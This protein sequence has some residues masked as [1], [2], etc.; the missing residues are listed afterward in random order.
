MLHEIKQPVRILH[1]VSVMNPGGIETLLIN[2]HRKI[3]RSKIQFDFLVQREQ[4]GLYEPEI[5][6]LGGRIYR[7]S[8]LTKVGPWKYMRLLEMFFK[9]HP[10]YQIV[11]SHMNTVSGLIL[12]AAEKAGVPVRIA[13]SHTVNPQSGLAETLF[14]NYYCRPKI[15][16]FATHFFACSQDAGR[17]LFGE[18]LAATRL[19]IVRNGIDTDRFGYNEQ[20]RLEMRKQLGL[21]NDAFVVGHVGRFHPVKNHAFLLDIFFELHKQKPEATLLLVGDGETKPE[22]ERNVQKMELTGA[23][24][25]LGIR[26]DVDKL[27]QA[28]DVFVFPSLYE[29]LPMVLVEAQAAGLPCIISDVIPLEVDINNTLITRLSLSQKASQWATAVLNAFPHVRQ[30]MSAEII[31]KGYDIQQTS[32][33]LQAFYLDQMAQMVMGAT[34]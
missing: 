27:L 3:D 20:T 2:V 28:M 7:V 24:R 32:D 18:K 12:Q 10:E 30:G 9:S 22:I 31:H 5:L 15:P 19:E 8:Y 4:V 25:F 17:W 13:H 29:G 26:N 33:E 1:V 23:I 11:H 21:K 16:H 6:A 14:K 34:H